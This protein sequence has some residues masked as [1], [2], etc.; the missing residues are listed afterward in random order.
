MAARSDVRRGPS[1]LE[2][3]AVPATAAMAAAAAAL[4]NHVE[5]VLGPELGELKPEQR[6]VLEAGW[7]TGRRLIGLIDDLQ[8]I[9]LAETGALEI[10]GTTVDL[11]ELATRA[12][13][14]AWPVA[15]T[16]AKTIRLEA[17]GPVHATGA[18]TLAARSLDA[19]LECAVEHARRDTEIALRIEAGAVT[20]AYESAE[21]PSGDELPVALA[22]AVCRLHG[23]DVVVGHEDGRATL[24]LR[25]GPA[26][27]DAVLAA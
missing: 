27:D 7:R 1:P 8:T 24:T 14:R 4:Q 26:G 22:T 10:E 19:L 9:A 18:E 17:D 16:Q 25:F 11:V 13:E 21:A 2:R 6:R 5:V 15:K 12:A 20:L 23:G 3:T